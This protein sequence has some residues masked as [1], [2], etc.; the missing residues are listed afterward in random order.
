MNWQES[1]DGF[2]QVRQRDGSTA[3]LP[4]NNGPFVLTDMDPKTYVPLIAK[5]IKILQQ[6]MDR[7]GKRYVHQWL[8]MAIECWEKQR[9]YLEK[10]KPSEEV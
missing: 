4:I 8:K 10:S 2:I 9:V 3:L 5:E 6:I 1:P 7:F